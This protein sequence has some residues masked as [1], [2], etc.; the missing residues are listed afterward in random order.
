MPATY[1]AARR[2]LAE[3]P[4]HVASILDAGAGPGAAAL[5]ARE[6][7]PEASLTLLERNPDLAE[8]SRD[9]LPGAAILPADLTKL[10]SFPP[11]DLVIA[12]YSLGEL[13]AQALPVGARLFQS[14]R[15][16]FAIIEPGTTKGF[17]LVRAIR[18]DLL[19]RGACVLSPCPGPVPCPMLDGDW[20]HF[21]AR[22]ERSSLHRRLKDGDLGYEDEKFS[23]VVLTKE[24]LAEP[25]VARILRHPRTNPGLIELTLCTPQG[26]DTRR[27]LKRD[28]DAFPYRPPRRLGQPPRVRRRPV[29]P[30]TRPL[31]R[32]RR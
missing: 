24:P 30:P 5:A 3:I 22:V 26:L 10:S 2:A 32:P 8:A 17:A 1:A 25:A 11:H 21:A 31:C 4:A 28:R 9:F 19:A 14:A 7:F 15:V 12:A 18:D 20:C 27:I 29:N 16:A 13:G 23:Y 6:L